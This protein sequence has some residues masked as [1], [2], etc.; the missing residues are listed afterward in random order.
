[1]GGRRGSLFF[2]RFA[3]E[4]AHAFFFFI[5][6]SLYVDYWCGFQK[7][8]KNESFLRRWGSGGS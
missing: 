1:M 5:L 6:L 4:I 2:R 7:E 3:A 8:W